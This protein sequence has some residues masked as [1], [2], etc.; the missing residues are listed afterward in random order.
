MIDFFSYQFIAQAIG[1]A[2]SGFII[3]SFNQ[4][5][6]NHL[7]ICLMIGNILNTFR[8]GSSIKFHKSTKMMLGFMAL[9]IL[10]GV[11]IYDKP[12]DLLPVLSALLGTYAMFKLS[13]IKLRLFGLI[14]SSAW[15]TYGIIFH[16]IGG[17]IAEISGLI[18]NISTILRLRRDN[19]KNSLNDQNT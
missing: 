8:I 18:L 9:Y 4:K 17:I 3:F 5:I 10:A 16:S 6:D 1:I 11:I 12:F 7:K 14:G 19:K 13:G 15:L 2:A